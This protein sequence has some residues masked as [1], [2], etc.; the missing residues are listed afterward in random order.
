MSIVF[1]IKNK[2]HISR[3]N[4][5]MSQTCMITFTISTI[6]IASKINDTLKGVFLSI[7]K[8]HSILGVANYLPIITRVKFVTAVKFH[9]RVLQL[10]AVIL[11]I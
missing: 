11:T 1:K 9:Y 2:G 4:M 5:Y 8:L 6:C 10:T 7:S 3:K